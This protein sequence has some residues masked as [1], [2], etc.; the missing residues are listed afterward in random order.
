MIHAG[1][2]LYIEI[3]TFYGLIIS[4]ILYLAFSYIFKIKFGI[5]YKHSLAFVKSTDEFVT[6][7]RF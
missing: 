7:T 1:K 4:A 3:Y 2:W 5:P 6:D